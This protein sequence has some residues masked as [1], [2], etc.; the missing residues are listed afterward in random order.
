M[1]NPRLWI[2]SMKYVAPLNVVICEIKSEI[3]RVGHS[4]CLGDKCQYFLGRILSWDE[5]LDSFDKSVKCR[6]RCH[7]GCFRP[8]CYSEWLTPSFSRKFVQSWTGP[9][10]ELTFWGRRS[11]AM[12][13]TCTRRSS[14]RSPLLGSATERLRSVAPQGGAEQERPSVVGSY[15]FAEGIAVGAP[16]VGQ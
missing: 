11:T 1:I 12:I 5:V 8:I 14:A 15:G 2:S 13:T 9:S 6:G 10:A 7:A 16:L 3:G 4:I